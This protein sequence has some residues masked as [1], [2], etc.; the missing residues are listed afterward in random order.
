M[1][2]Y[3]V[4]IVFYSTPFYCLELRLFTNIQDYIFISSN[5]YKGSGM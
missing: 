1:H 5:S 4:V 3:I 2:N